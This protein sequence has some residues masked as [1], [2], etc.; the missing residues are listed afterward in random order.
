MAHA[1]VLVLREAEAGEDDQFEKKKKRK[2]TSQSSLR[3]EVGEV[4]VSPNRVHL[5]YYP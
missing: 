1:I 5:N 3:S 4:C 2:E